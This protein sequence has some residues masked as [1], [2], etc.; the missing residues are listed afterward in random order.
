MSVMNKER[1]IPEKLKTVAFNDFTISITKTT[2]F[3][4]MIAE[5]TVDKLKRIKKKLGLN[6]DIIKD[7]IY[8]NPLI[9]IDTYDEEGDVYEY[10][11]EIEKKMFKEGLNE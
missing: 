11:K 10:F 6:S 7:G 2:L 3:Y 4:D 5:G 1:E 9:V 8:G